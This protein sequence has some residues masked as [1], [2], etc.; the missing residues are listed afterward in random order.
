M[1]LNFP[2]APVAY[3]QDHTDQ[4]QHAI[5]GAD[6]KTIKTDRSINRLLFVSPNGTLYYMSVSNAGAT[7]W[8]AA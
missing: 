6:K 3:D 7:V 1:A 8:T 2:P 4:V 5:E